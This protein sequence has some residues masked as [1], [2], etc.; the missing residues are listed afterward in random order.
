LRRRPER[1]IIGKT[2]VED[3]MDNFKRVLSTVLFIAGVLWQL[4]VV[5]GFA[6]SDMD[7]EDILFVA[8]FSLITVGVLYAS[9]RIRVSGS[10]KKDA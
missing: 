9:L 6:S 10:H 7:R 3:A 5:L 1:G 4:F 2:A 8:L